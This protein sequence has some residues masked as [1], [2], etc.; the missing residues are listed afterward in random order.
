M[1]TSDIRHIIRDIRLLAATIERRWNKNLV[2]LAVR[3]DAERIRQTLDL[4]AL[5]RCIDFVLDEPPA[6][7]VSG[8]R[9]AERLN[10]VLS[11]IEDNRE[12]IVSQLTAA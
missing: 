7:G 9:A 2:T 5:Q 4:Q 12:V 3:T 8:Y 11:V 10:R 1:D 6:E